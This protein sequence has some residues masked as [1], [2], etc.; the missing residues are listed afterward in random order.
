MLDTLRGRAGRI[1]L[2]LATSWGAVQ[3]KR[4]G[5]KVCRMTSQGLAD[6]A[7][8][9]MVCHSTQETRVHGALDDVA[10]NICQAL[11]RGMGVPFRIATTSGGAAQVETT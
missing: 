9:D 2:E 11:L 1:L 3:L 10:C 6:I 8:H 7:R 4:H 5:F